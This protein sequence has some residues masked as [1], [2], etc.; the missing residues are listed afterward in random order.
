MKIVWEKDSWWWE[1]MGILLRDGVKY[2]Y[3]G[4]VGHIR[5]LPSWLQW[6][7]EFH[8]RYPDKVAHAL[9]TFVLALL[10][11]RWFPP[12]HAAG[13]AFLAMVGYEFLPLL[14]GK[15]A[16]VSVKDI[17]ADLAGAVLWLAAGLAEW[18]RA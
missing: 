5:P 2:I 7:P 11:S 4:S 12:N 8:L 13:L 15:V 16:Y 9:V 1:E 10:L 14:W 6:L 18:V 17:L 3:F